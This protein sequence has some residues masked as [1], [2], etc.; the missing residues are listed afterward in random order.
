MSNIQ[1]LSMLQY[2]ERKYT[3]DRCVMIR[4]FDC[5]LDKDLY[6]NAVF[7]GR[8]ELVRVYT[9]DDADRGEQN[10][11]T[12]ETAGDIIADL[13]YAKELNKDVRVHC[14]A[15]L[16]RSGAVTQFAIDYLGFEDTGRP[17]VPNAHVYQTLV[18]SYTGLTIEQQV[19][20]AFENYMPGEDV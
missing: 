6:P 7:D 3:A 5:T 10:A 9:F 8:D 15:G 12:L 18:E 17:R 13:K 1:N 16:S 4:I 14:L 20:K 2:L 11:L 19:I